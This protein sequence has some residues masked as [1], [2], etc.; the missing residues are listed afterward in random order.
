MCCIAP[1]SQCCRGSVHRP[2]PRFQQVLIGLARCASSIAVNPAK[3]MNQLPKSMRDHPTCPMQVESDAVETSNFAGG[4]ACCHGGGAP[5][6]DLEKARVAYQARDVVA[7]RCGVFTLFC[8]LASV[9][10][11]TT[12]RR[13]CCGW[14]VTLNGGVFWSALCEFRHL[15]Y[16]WCRA[17]HN[18]NY[19]SELPSG[20]C[21]AH[22][23][24]SSDYL[25]AIV[26]GGLDGRAFRPS[27]QIGIMF[28]IYWY[29]ILEK[30]RHYVTVA[31]TKASHI[32]VT[33]VHS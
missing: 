22:K 19:Y 7:T 5:Y 26:F 29:S 16:L 18:T 28:K 30:L 25:K 3:C 21:E 24:T 8:Y 33:K 15:C 4:G 20:H 31:L 9:T 14:M 27:L 1:V 12:S 23:N 17:A 2:Q 11:F 32:M 13:G 6:R 10:A